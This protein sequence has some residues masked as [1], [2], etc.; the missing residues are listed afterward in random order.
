MNPTIVV[1]PSR[2][3]HH[4]WDL[5]TGP[6][7][8]KHTLNTLNPQESNKASPFIHRTGVRCPFNVVKWKNV[9]MS[10]YYSYCNGTHK[11]RLRS[12]NSWYT[13]VRLSISCAFGSNWWAPNNEQAAM[14]HSRNG[15]EG[16]LYVHLSKRNE[17]W[18]DFMADTGDGGNSTYSIA[19]LLAQPSLCVTDEHCRTY[20]ELPR[21]NLLL[22]GGDLALV[23][24]PNPFMIWHIFVLFA[25]IRSVG[26]SVLIVS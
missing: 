22:V 5:G 21:S 11:G 3:H 19:R 7:H 24:H 26:R 18:L 23:S 17:L 8:N 4:A 14:A 6:I 20:H 2:F 15:R 16:S 25:C 13:T 1:L 12:L 10:M 9:M